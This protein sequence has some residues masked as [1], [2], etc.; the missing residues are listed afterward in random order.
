[1]ARRAVAA[2]SPP[3]DFDF[4]AFFE[5]A[6]E[7]FARPAA[8]RLFP[9]V[10]PALRALR[11]AGFPLAVFSNWDGRLPGLLDDFG[12][13]GFFA[14]V[15]A[16]ADLPAAKP[17]REAFEAVAAELAGLAGGEPPVLVGDRRDH[18]VEPALAAGWRAVWLDRAGRGDATPDGGV[19]IGDLR[20][21]PAALEPATSLP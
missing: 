20:E 15:L 21:L 11:G 14:R 18:D 13:G 6:W 19:R 4:D 17:A 16:S 9:D 2:A 5:R 10:R 7:H 1:V 3:A 8:W 12:V